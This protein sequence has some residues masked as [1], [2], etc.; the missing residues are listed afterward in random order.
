MGWDGLTPLGDIIPSHRPLLLLREKSK[1]DNGSGVTRD[2]LATEKA[3][4][5]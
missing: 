4:Q 2:A 5:A 3:R 1:S